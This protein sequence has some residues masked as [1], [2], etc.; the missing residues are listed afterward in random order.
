MSTITRLS[1]LCL[2]LVPATGLA[3]TRTWDPSETVEVDTTLDTGIVLVEDGGGGTSG[4]EDDTGEAPDRDPACPGECQ[5]QFSSCQV[6][7][8]TTYQ[9]CRANA[10]EHVNWLIRYAGIIDVDLLEDMLEACELQGGAAV[11]SCS[12]EL[13]ACQAAC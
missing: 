4:G 8:Y 9:Q 5:D 12:Y 1:A 10:Y 13:E 6:G 2:A 11:D 7:V 3:F